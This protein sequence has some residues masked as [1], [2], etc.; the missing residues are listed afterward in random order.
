MNDAQ[1]HVVLL[2][3]T[4]QPIATMDK[5]AVHHGSTPLH[6]AFS[7]YIFDLDGRVLLISPWAAEQIS[8]LRAISPCGIGH[9]SHV[10]AACSR[11]NLQ[12]GLGG[13]EA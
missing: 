2:D 4:G 11:S 6:L 8:L 13:E 3:D 10:G 9:R 5:A 7:C 12:V 1:D